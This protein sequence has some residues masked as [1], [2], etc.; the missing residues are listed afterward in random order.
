MKPDLPLPFFNSYVLRLKKLYLP[1]CLSFISLTHIIC[2]K[3][4]TNNILEEDSIPS[5]EMVERSPLAN[6]RVM[7]DI[8]LARK[9]NHMDKFFGIYL[10]KRKSS[11]LSCLELLCGR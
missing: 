8:Q 5:F 6:V 10:T 2:Y 7:N 9:K 11:G 1:I 3:K 4:S